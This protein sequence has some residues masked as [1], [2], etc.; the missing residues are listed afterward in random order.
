[1]IIMSCWADLKRLCLAL[2]AEDQT[3][4]LGN[5]Q[6]PAALI[7]VTKQRLLIFTKIFR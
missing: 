2:F 6:R 3:L 1:M 5:F 4:I 7:G